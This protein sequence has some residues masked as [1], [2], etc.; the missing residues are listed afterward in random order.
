MEQES[1]GENWTYEFRVVENV[2]PVFV[3]A[4]DRAICLRGFGKTKRM[5]KEEEGRGLQCRLSDNLPLCF[6]L[7]GWGVFGE[8]KRADFVALYSTP[9]EIDPT[10]SGAMTSDNGDK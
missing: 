6:R 8:R 4:L 7:T 10:T 2:L 1:L 5:S 3:T 9:S